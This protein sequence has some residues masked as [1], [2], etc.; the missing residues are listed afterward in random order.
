MKSTTILSALVGVSYALVYPRAV[1][2][3]A[4]G[5]TSNDCPVP[6]ADFWALSKEVASNEKRELAERQASGNDTLVTRHEVTIDTWIHV[7][8][9]SYKFEDGYVSDEAILKQMEVINEAFNKRQFNF[10]LVGITRTIDADL[11]VVDADEGIDRLGQRLR[12]GDFAT[13][14]LYVVKD[15]PGNTAGDCTL[16]VSAHGG[17]FLGDGCRFN[18]DTLPTLSSGRVLIHEV[19]H[20]LGLGHTFQEDSANP[21]CT[22]GHG[23]DVADTPVHL[24]PTDNSCTPV[25]TCP[26]L[27]GQDP[28]NNYMNYTPNSCWTGFTDGQA[29][30]MHS[31]WEVRKKAI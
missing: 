31:M 6:G 17:K 25:D 16:P 8:S 9:S 23:D 3:K 7:V 22:T 2:N 13:L 12:K 24:R 19:G 21:T 27:P 30:R 15:L 10:R 14:N 20:W 11:S 26:G 5:F 29:T 28:I 1:E 4:A 18:Y